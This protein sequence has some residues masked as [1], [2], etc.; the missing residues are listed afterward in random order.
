MKLQTV[1]EQLHETSPRGSECDI[2]R[3]TATPSRLTYRWEQTHAGS[4]PAFGRALEREGCRGLCDRL[5]RPAPASLAALPLPAGFRWSAAAAGSPIA[6]SR[7]DRPPRP[8][9]VDRKIVA[10]L[11]PTSQRHGGAVAILTPVEAESARCVHTSRRPGSPS[12][13]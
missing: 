2:E 13:W 8:G 5:G 3:T 11:F 6:R 4:L 7:T 12:G 1:I 9:H 10:R